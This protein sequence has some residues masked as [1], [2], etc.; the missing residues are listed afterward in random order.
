MKST[1]DDPS[2]R[3]YAAL[4]LPGLRAQGGGASNAKPVAA[5]VIAVSDFL[6]AVR[7]DKLL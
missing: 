1:R 4:S 2:V 3:D 7:C 5:A 6:R